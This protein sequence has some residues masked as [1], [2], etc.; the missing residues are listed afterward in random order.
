RPRGRSPP[1]AAAAGDAPVVAAGGIADGRG[2]AAAI[3]LGA[4]GASLG[5]RFLATTEMGIDDS[6]KQRI[7]DASP[8]DS[9]KVAHAERVMPPF[10]LPQIGVPNVPRSLR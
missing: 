8:L 1:G 4:Q 10:N 3:A 6:G 9:V 7:V 5:T 2:I